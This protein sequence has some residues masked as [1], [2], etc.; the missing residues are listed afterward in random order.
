MVDNFAQ[1]HMRNLQRTASER[2]P[3]D[4]RAFFWDVDPDRLS[5]SK[6]AHFIISRLMEHGDEIALRFLLKTYSHDELIRVL[7]N[8]R[9]I[10]RRSRLFW[11]LL[12]E[13]DEK[14]CTPKRYPTP[15]GNCSSA[16]IDPL[17]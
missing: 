17:Y 8:S 1:P 13:I 14:S 7:K 5:I 11:S 9:S 4:I 2:L 6:S 15:Y 3:T 10:S 12:L 16:S